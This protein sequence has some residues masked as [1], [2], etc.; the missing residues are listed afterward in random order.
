[1]EIQ[2]AIIHRIKKAKDT[3][4]DESV[5]V[6]PRGAELARDEKLQTLGEEI[7]KLY[8]TIA[9]SYGTLGTDMAIHR[10]PNFLTQTIG[11]DLDFIQFSIATTRVIAELMSQ[12]RMT[13]TSYPIF[14]RYTNQGR[15]W[16]LIAMLKLK[17]GI[18]LD[19]DTLEL[20]DSLAF[21]VGDL[22][23]A[24]RVDLAKWQANDQPY[25]SFVKRGSG[26]DSESSKYFRD[27]LSCLDYTD[28]KHNTEV[29]M[30]A[31]D[32]YCHDSEWD[33][34]KW[35]QARA[36]TYTYCKEKT[37][38]GEPVNLIALSAILN[39]QHPASFA[40]Y[41]RENNYEV[42]ETFS[43]H[44]AT[45]KR[46]HR[47]TKRYGTISL[48]FDVED[49]VRGNVQFIEEDGSIVL[50]NPPADLVAEIHKALGSQPE[51]DG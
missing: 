38:A 49:L 4:G 12:Q 13:T 11:G 15:D 14:F 30:T 45:Y 35:S 18:G 29:V 6:K 47:L 48:G 17:V 2:Q 42:S 50:P 37:E 43:P 20:N 21:D 26:S 24:A 19:E 5:S 9:N 16:L 27:A 7:L 51:N 46:F 1:M 8:G 22:R 28:A 25:L 44:P 40:D 36:K 23:E 34:E 32:D 31:V 3:S 10:F 41:V 33:G 39:D